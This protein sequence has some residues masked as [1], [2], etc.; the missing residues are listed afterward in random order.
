MSKLW[1]FVI[2]HKLVIL[3][4]LV[5]GYLLFNNNLLPKSSTVSKSTPRQTLEQ[6]LPTAGVSRESLPESA[7]APTETQDRMT[8]KETS[9]S[10]VVKD[11]SGALDGISKKAEELGGF[12][13]DSKLDVGEGVTSGTVT[14]RVPEARRQE[15]INEFKKMA[16]KVV[17]ESVSGYDV[18]DEYVDLN[19]RL[20]VLTKTKAKFEAILAS[21]TSVSDLLEVQRELV[22]VQSQIDSVVGQQKYLEQSA[23]L[24][25]VTVYLSTDELSLPYTPDQAWRPNVVFKQATRSL[26]GFARSL[27]SLAI[28]IGVFTPVWLPAAVI[29]K[30]LRHR[31]KLRKHAG[32]NTTPSS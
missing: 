9:L 11:V 32:P 3:L 14:I 17:S 12:L 15:A 4:L 28:W 22:D 20:A 2:K 24:A 1:A 21:A 18:T 6:S 30:W 26:V 27:G 13:T 7:P 5:V 8:I 29:F 16:V 19:A 10:L 23:K 25:L 31:N